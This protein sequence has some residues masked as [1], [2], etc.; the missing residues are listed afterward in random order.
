MA[1]RSIRIA[2]ACA[3]M[4]GGIAG[5]TRDW[6]G[7]G[8]G[9]D[10]GMPDV[11]SAE[12]NVVV[13]LGGCSGILLTPQIVATA[14]HCVYG[15]TS[16]GDCTFDGEPLL[17]TATVGIV[18]AGPPEFASVAAV[19][20]IAGCLDHDHN[21][22]HD[23]ALLYLE[24]PVTTA[25]I[26]A[27]KSTAPPVVPR[28]IRPKLEAPPCDGLSCDAGC[29]TWPWVLGASGYG[30]G[31]S[32]GSGRRRATLF[33]DGSL[34]VVDDGEDTIWE[35]AGEQWINSRGD[36]G[37]PLFVQ[38]RDGRREVIGIY[39]GTI[40]RP[41][42]PF[43]EVMR[44][45]DLTRGDSR[46]WL[47]ERVVEAGVP[48]ALRHTPRWLA[49]H[50]KT[51]DSWW[52]ELDYSGPCDPSLDQDCDGWWD[53]GPV[54]HD[55]CPPARCGDDFEAC[56]NPDQADR[57]DDGIGDACPEARAVPRRARVRPMQ[58]RGSR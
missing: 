22:A 25:S 5:D 35:K 15:S 8:P 10:N 30:T 12:A 51:E 23:V 57:D 33:E 54:V 24:E 38:G 3:C 37:G 41:F 40:V 27:R 20:R 31:E 36:S 52:G 4:A 43:N 39:S 56:A 58:R 21:R 16:N 1:G 7:C 9:D 2:A 34:D 32:G 11:D 49:A 44:W 46:R 48:E 17:K 6:L 26:L 53:E 29:G 47:L 45:A 19:A 14:A 18:G 28:V 50:G 13:A 55:N 42:V